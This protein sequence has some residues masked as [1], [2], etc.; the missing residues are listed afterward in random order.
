[1]LVTGFEPFAGDSHNP[2]GSG[3]ARLA[4]QQ[5]QGRWPKVVFGVLPVTWT[6]APEALRRLCDE[7]HP[8]AVLMFGLAA[9]ANTLRVERR[10]FNSAGEGLTDND[11]VQGTGAPLVPDA[12]PSVMT[13]ADIGVFAMDLATAGVPVEISDDPGRFLCNAVY[14]AALTGCQDSAARTVFV[15]VPATRAV[16]GTLDDAV[17]EG[18]IETAV[19]VYARLTGAE[20]DT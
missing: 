19:A 8:D 15:H 11:G 2:S 10:A 18:W 20:T 4:R 3:V 17:V 7:V 16:G 9:T 14:H 13:E 1:M 5:A 12:E 6:A